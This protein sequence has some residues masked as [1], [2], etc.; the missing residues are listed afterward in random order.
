[1]NLKALQ[2]PVAIHD[3]QS[4]VEAARRLGLNQSAVSMQIKALER[5]LG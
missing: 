5:E 3:G 1:M 2:S 4:F